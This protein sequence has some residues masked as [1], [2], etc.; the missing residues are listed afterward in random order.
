MSG[1]MPVKSSDG[2]APQVRWIARLLG[3]GC[4]LELVGGGSNPAINNYNTFLWTLVYFEVGWDQEKI[5]E[6]ECWT[7][8]VSS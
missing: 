5:K 6:E 3:S 4:P 2:G 1:S 7:P 8:I